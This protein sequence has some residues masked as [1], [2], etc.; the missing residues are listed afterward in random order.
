MDPSEYLCKYKNS[1]EPKLEYKFKSYTYDPNHTYHEITK[2]DKTTKHNITTNH[3]KTKQNDLFKN[4]STQPFSTRNAII[5][6]NIDMV[7]NFSKH[8]D[9][10]IQK[11]NNKKYIF[12][13]LN[14]DTGLTQYI[15]YRNPN[16]QGYGVY[17]TLCSCGCLPKVINTCT[18]KNP[19]K[20]GLGKLVNLT[21]II[22][23]TMD[24][25]T[26]QIKNF[27][28]MKVDLVVNGDSSKFKDSL[29]VALKTLNNEGV[30]ITPITNDDI[31]ILYMAS[32]TFG[33]I[34]LF[35]PISSG[36][37]SFYVIC[38]D[39]HINNIDYINDLQNNKNIN[40]PTNFINW[41]KSF[42]TNNYPTTNNTTDDI[43][44]YK[45][46]AIWNLPQL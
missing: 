14:D 12:A 43:N 36:P 3:D 34:T 32:L 5:L 10:Y 31:N 4:V 35:K 38:Q 9:G 24:T 40:V 18:C 16:S 33:K 22:T 29:L 42:P 13:A 27:N 41:F 30:F 26:C 20:D 44:I 6:A 39:I 2:H 7:F 45:C 46:K 11:Q 21:K 15:M 25:I 37:N 28:P 23:A 8:T 1:F 19:N 17:D